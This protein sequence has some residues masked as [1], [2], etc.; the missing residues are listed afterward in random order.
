MSDYQ[1][2][3]DTRGFD[4]LIFAFLNIR[5][6]INIKC[7][8]KYFGSRYIFFTKWVEWHFLPKTEIKVFLK[9]MD[10]RGFG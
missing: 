5:V 8:N 10:L 3:M 2:N 7:D 9:K 1:S 6:L 4:W